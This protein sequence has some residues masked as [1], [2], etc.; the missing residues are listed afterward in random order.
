MKRNREITLI[1]VFGLAVF[2][3]GLLTLLFGVGSTYYAFYTPGNDYWDAWAGMS[4]LIGFVVTAAG[5][6][7]YTWTV[8]QGYE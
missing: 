4:L 6:I 7:T 8:G 1:A 5:A 3:V 2:F